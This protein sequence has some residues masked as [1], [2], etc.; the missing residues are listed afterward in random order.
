MIVLN[1]C[2]FGQKYQNCENK[3]LYANYNQDSPSWPTLNIRPELRWPSS[4]IL[5]NSAPCLTGSPPLNT[6]QFKFAKL[7]LIVSDVTLKIEI[8]MKCIWK[9]LIMNLTSSSQKVFSSLTLQTYQTYIQPAL[10]VFEWLSM[11]FLASLLKTET[12][13]M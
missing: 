6:K 8:E 2:S 5:S 12:L 10:K 3:L 1:Y 11:M 9:G 4:S 7:V 13:V